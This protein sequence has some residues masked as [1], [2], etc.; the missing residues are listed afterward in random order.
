MFTWKD[1]LTKKDTTTM[2]NSAGRYLGVVRQPKQA[3]AKTTPKARFENLVPIKQSY[4][5]QYYLLE[6]KH[7]SKTIDG[8]RVELS[9][10]GIAKLLKDIG[11]GQYEFSDIKKLESFS[12]AKNS[13]FQID[14][15]G[16]LFSIS[17]KYH[18]E[19]SEKIYGL[20]KMH[21]SANWIQ[22]EITLPTLLC[23]DNDPTGKY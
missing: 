12:N 3:G 10:I 14:S 8:Q 21:K 4:D 22:M 16:A 9:E 18:D 17:F 5:A 7:G 1:F 2:F 19:G 20:S 13:Y 15:G 6:R 11:T 23:G